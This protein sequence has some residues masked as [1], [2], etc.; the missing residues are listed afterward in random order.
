MNKQTVAHSYNRIL[1]AIKILIHTKCTNFKW[2]IG[3]TET[4]FKVYYM[5][6]DSIYM[7]F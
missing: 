7:T 2:F 4:G 6:Y 3:K 1:S 5:T